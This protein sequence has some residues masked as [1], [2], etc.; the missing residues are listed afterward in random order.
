MTLINFDL[1]LNHNC[2]GFDFID[3][4]GRQPE[5]TDGYGEGVDIAGYTG[6]IEFET[7]EGNVA[8]SSSVTPSDGNVKQFIDL[9]EVMPESAY[10]NVRYTVF[11]E[12]GTEVGRNTHPVLIACDFICKLQS[13]LKKGTGTCKCSKNVMASANEARQSYLSSLWLANAGDVFAA[14]DVFK[15]AQ[16]KIK[17]TNCKC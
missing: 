3:T 13:A 8:F 10:Y 12:N 15:Y 17:G 7:L 4:T 9:S 5:V 11:D 1:C 14:Q 16:R 2:S 6:S